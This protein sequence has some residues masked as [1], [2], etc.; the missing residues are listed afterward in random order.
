[1]QKMLLVALGLMLT[2]TAFADETQGIRIE[3]R[4]GERVQVMKDQIIVGHPAK[5]LAVTDVAT[6]PMKTTMTE[7]RQPF[8]QRIA[9]TVQRAPF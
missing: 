8:V 4:N 1:M 2:T 3:H 7:L 9:P 5:P 6:L